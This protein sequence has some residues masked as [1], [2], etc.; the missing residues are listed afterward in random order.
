MEVDK[1][2]EEIK[3]EPEKSSASLLGAI[4]DLFINLE[5]SIGHLSAIRQVC[6]LH[7]IPNTCSFK[8]DEKDVDTSLLNVLSYQLNLH[9]DI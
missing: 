9:F 2:G 5:A 6:A 3:K 7:F 8:I 1:F 4:N